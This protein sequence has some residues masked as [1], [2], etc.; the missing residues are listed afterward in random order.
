MHHT[1]LNIPDLFLPLLRGKVKKRSASEIDT[2][3]FATLRSDD[4]WKA[5]GD[6]IA[7]CAPHWPGSFDRVPRNPAEKLNS[8]YKAWEFGLY[9][10]GIGPAAF[11]DYLHDRFYQNYCLMVKVVRKMIQH[12]ITVKEVQESHKV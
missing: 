10:Y 3:D 8:G 7:S 4:V 12:E 6:F 11:L 2:W 9:L 1:H 5:H